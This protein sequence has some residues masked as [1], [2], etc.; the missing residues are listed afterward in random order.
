VG[1][2]FQQWESDLEKTKE[3]EAKLT[4]RN[5]S[6]NIIPKKLKEHKIAALF[7]LAL[8]EFLLK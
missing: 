8:P 2:V 3:Q 5:P 1:A 4:V 6:F 7:R